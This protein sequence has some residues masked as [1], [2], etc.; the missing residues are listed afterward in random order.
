ML[1]KATPDKSLY[2]FCLNPDMPGYFNL[3]FKA[4]QHAPVVT[5]VR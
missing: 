1:V 5:W 4:N 2:A 3:M